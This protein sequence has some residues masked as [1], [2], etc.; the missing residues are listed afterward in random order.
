[1]GSRG[2]RVE[3]KM[4]KAKLTGSSASLRKQRKA[5]SDFTIRRLLS[6]V[7]LPE[8]RLSQELS[9]FLKRRRQRR[10]L[11][12]NHKTKTKLLLPSLLRKTLSLS[13]R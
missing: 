6:R 13:E 9:S 4:K 3:S 2:K 1:M 10:F 12:P 5:P 8:R 7:S 11:I